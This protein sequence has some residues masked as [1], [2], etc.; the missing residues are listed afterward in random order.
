MRCL[1]QQ[2]RDDDAGFVLSAELVMVGSVLVIGLVV[3]LA[4]VQEAVI[5]EYQDVAG[6]LRGLDQSYAYHGMHGCGCSPCSYS[7]WTAGSSYGV[8]ESGLP[9]CFDYVA[10]PAGEFLIAPPVLPTAPL[11]ECNPC[12]FGFDIPPAGPCVES[13]P[14]ATRPGCP[15]V[16]R[17]CQSECRIAVIEEPPVRPCECPDRSQETILTTCASD[18]YISPSPPGPFVW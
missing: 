14:C 8:S 12:G 11:P 1:W 6:A 2:L 17:P 16:Q 5:G 15:V 7:S 18:S 10:P 9:I 3:G 4:S 13:R